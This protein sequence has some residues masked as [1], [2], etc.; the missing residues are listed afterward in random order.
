[1]KNELV[2]VSEIVQSDRVEIGRVV[3]K[4]SVENCVSILRKETIV[5][6]WQ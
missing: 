2:L 4:Y 5:C 6:Q 3:E 1:M